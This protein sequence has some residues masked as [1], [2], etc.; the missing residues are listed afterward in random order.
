M[1]YVWSNAVVSLVPPLNQSFLQRWLFSFTWP[2]SKSPSPRSVFNL[3]FPVWWDWKFSSSLS[4]TWIWQIAIN[5]RQHTASQRFTALTSINLDG[6]LTT[7]CSWEMCLPSHGYSKFYSKFSYFLIKFDIWNNQT[8]KSQL[9]NSYHI[10]DIKTLI[11]SQK[12]VYM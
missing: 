3:V 6:T 4:L 11:T 2:A 9:N 12:N 8:T 7:T 1:N 5:C 10:T